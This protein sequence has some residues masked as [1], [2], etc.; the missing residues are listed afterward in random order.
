MPKPKRVCQLQGNGRLLLG[1][2]PR[3]VWR[4][5][6]PQ[7]WLSVPWKQGGLSQRRL[8]HQPQRV[9]QLPRIGRLL[10]SRLPCV[11]WWGVLPRSWPPVS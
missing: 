6:L 1:K 4:R 7:G 8:L 11:V 5:H 3:V 10:L 2:L 9:C